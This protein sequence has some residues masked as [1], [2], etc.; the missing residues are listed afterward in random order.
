MIKAIIDAKYYNEFNILQTDGIYKYV[1]WS[2][3]DNNVI[4]LAMKPG[5]NIVIITYKNQTIFED[6]ELKV[7]KS[8][9]QNF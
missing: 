1:S 2:F 5:T 4:I 8:Q 7:N 9:I 3:Q 6:M